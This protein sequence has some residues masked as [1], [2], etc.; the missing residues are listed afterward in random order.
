MSIYAFR[1]WKAS[2]RGLLTGAFGVAWNNGTMH[3]ECKAVPECEW[4]KVP[5]TLGCYCGFYGSVDVQD[6]IRS[7]GHWSIFG[8]VQMGGSVIPHE[9]GFRSSEARIAAL[10]RPPEIDSR[11]DIL[12]TVQEF[13]AILSNPERLHEKHWQLQQEFADLFVNG[14]EKLE[15]SYYIGW[16]TRP[17]DATDRDAEVEVWREYQDRLQHLVH[18]CRDHAS[19]LHAHRARASWETVLS[20]YPNVAVFDSVEAALREF[21]LSDPKD[22]VK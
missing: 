6:V 18:Q 17:D 13:E 9:T 5:P 7:E 20:I 8:I 15:T 10:V 3:A 22:Y 1:S 12:G 4:P 16:R 14:Q 21:P 11:P 2:R 19:R